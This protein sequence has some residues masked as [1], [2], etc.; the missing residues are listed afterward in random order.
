MFPGHVMR[1]QSENPVCVREQSNSRGSCICK[2][3]PTPPP[4]P[5]FLNNDQGETENSLF[6]DLA[7]PPSAKS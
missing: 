6:P 1:E 4:G 5:T 3:F 7:G 2:C